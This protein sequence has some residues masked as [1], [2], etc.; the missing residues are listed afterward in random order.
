MLP[1]AM[2]GGTGHRR[3][4]ERNHP[5]G[6]A[7]GSRGDNRTRNRQGARHEP[8]RIACCRWASSIWAPAGPR[9]RRLEVRGPTREPRPDMHGSTIARSTAEPLEP[10]VSTPSPAAV[11]R[12]AP[13]AGSEQPR[14]HR[15]RTRNG[16]RK[17]P[18]IANSHRIMMTVL[19]QP[20]RRS[21]RCAQPACC[22]G[23]GRSQLAAGAPAVATPGT[24]P[25]GSRSFRTG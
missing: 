25:S 1:T 9:R 18:C 15:A 7:D 17:R 23:G 14:D 8:T 21:P 6:Q 3:F 16:A 12:S 13:T 24:P 10:T 4:E 11:G 19:P 2:A 20:R 22:G 5:G